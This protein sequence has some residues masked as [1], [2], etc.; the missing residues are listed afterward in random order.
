MELKIKEG[1]EGIKRENNTQKNTVTI[2]PQT[3]ENKRG[4]NN[5]NTVSN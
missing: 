4:E 3:I 5:G 2:N 1:S